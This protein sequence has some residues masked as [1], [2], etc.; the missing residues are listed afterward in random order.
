M[1]DLNTN[2]T[3][4]DF[5]SQLRTSLGS[6]ACPDEIIAEVRADFEAQV[7]RLCAE[8]MG[9][10]EAIGRAL[11]Q[12]GNPYELAHHI[13]AERAPLPGRGMRILRMAATFVV[14]TWTLLML[15]ALRP[16]A[17]GSGGVAVTL[18]VAMFHLP[19][20]LLLW[21]GIVWR[22]NWLFGLLPAALGLIALVFMSAGGVS[23]TSEIVIQLEGSADL[24]SVPAQIPDSSKQINRL[25]LIRVT[26]FLSFGSACVILFLMM[27][28]RAQRRRAVGL[29]IAGLLLAELPFQIEEWRFRVGRDHL[30]SQSGAPEQAA[31][32]LSPRYRYRPD[33]DENDFFL[34]WSRP[35]SPGF[36]LCYGSERDE[37]WV[38]D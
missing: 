27:Q 34:S 2:P 5:F 3:A 17:Y 36:A 12:L 20:I 35:I 38:I 22:R 33:S 29:L 18:G 37:T 21:P 15:W 11:E 16:G 31:E 30:T 24:A 7:E 14:I 25:L 9:E 10:A 6:S 28:Q 4:T 26:L 1:S 19:V 23:Q 32:E 8:G 13:R